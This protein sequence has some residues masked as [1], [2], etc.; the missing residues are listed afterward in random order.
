MNGVFGIYFEGPKNTFSATSKYC[1]LGIICWES[2]YRTSAGVWMSRDYERISF[3][4]RLFRVQG[5]CYRGMLEFLRMV[6]FMAGLVRCL[7]V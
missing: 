7:S 4:N 6:L 1:L 2:K 3:I 5:V